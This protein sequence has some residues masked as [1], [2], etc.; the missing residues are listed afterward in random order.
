MMRFDARLRFCVAVILLILTAWG[1]AAALSNRPVGDVA[2]LLA[3]QAALTIAACLLVWRHAGD[4]PIDLRVVMPLHILLYS[5][6]SNV[7]PALLPRLRP[8]E[9]ANLIALRMP[10]AGAG[11]YATATLAALGLLMGWAAGLEVVSHLAP[12]SGSS[13]RRAAGLPSG[14]TA[15]AALVVLLVLVCACTLRYGLEFGVTLTDENVVSMPFAEQLLFHGLFW[16]LPVGPLLA[17]VA[18]MRR[19]RP[20]RFETA[21]LMGIALVLVAVL[22]V[23]RMRSTAMLAV[24]LPVVV[25]AAKGRIDAR[26]WAVPAVLLVGGAYAAIT[27]VR[28][29]GLEQAV[30]ERQGRLSI[31]ELLDALARRSPEQT[32]SGRA[33]F[34]ASYRTAGLEPVAALVAAQ[35][36]GRLKP[37]EGRVARAGFQQALPAALRPG[38]DVPE[39]VKTAPSH[40]GIFTEGDW[41]TTFEAEAVLDAGPAFT[42]LPGFLAGLLLGVV[43][44]VLLRLGNSHGFDGVLVVRTAFL[45]YPIAVGASVA[46]MTLLFFKGTAGY[47]VLFVPAGLI[48]ARLEAVW[49]ARSAGA[50]I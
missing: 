32:V 11:D 18:W 8:A 31:S 36:N 41:V 5:G 22:A 24:V 23:W 2:L 13:C 14:G 26:R 30:S 45:L 6:L 21:G 47:A 37:Q 17:A 44:L 28:I 3:A 39:R 20:G 38:L 15:R 33:L 40:F 50:C 46:D 27:V 4:D 48:A 43:D 12:A 42:F 9:L 49:R 7:V 16:F 29:S 25:L 19:T 35:S 10:E 34:D 1:A